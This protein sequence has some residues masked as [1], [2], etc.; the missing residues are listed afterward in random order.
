MPVARVLVHHPEGGFDESPPLESISDLIE[1]PRQ[2]VWLDIEDPNDDDVELLRTEFGF[3]E[4]ALEDAIRRDQRPKIDSY[5]GYHFVVFYTVQRGRTDEVGI[6]VGPNYLV[7]VHAGPCLEVASTAA[8]WRLNADRLG[9]SIEVPFYSLLDAIVDGYF[10][11]ID[12]ITEEVEDIETAMFEPGGENRQQQVFVIKRELLNLRRLIAPEREVLNALIRRDD[13]ILGEKALPYFQD[14]YDHLIRVLDSVDLARDQLTGLLDA[15]LSVVS[16]RLNV[17][18]KRMTALSTILMSAN[19][20]AA[21]YGMNFTVMPELGWPFG[22]AWAL[23]LML[24]I[25]AT[26]AWVFKRIDWL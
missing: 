24:A 14:I 9:N 21:N 6:F 25:C 1:D 20:V 10:P 16:N 4:L 5:D 11:V 2:V 8:R 13:P 22:Y 23:V 18:M 7:T 19:L 15:H 26:L 12:E 3:H 17:V